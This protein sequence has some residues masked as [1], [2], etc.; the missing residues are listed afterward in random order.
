MSRHLGH[1]RHFGG[2]IKREDAFFCWLG[3]VRLSRIFQTF[4]NHQVDK[5]HYIPHQ[6]L[7]HLEQKDS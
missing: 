3:S 4:V 7:S 6:L 2:E 5:P 1:N